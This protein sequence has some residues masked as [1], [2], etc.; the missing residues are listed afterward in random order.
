MSTTPY[1]AEEMEA[2][3]I[4]QRSGL[5]RIVPENEVYKGGEEGTRWWVKL[6]M[7]DPVTLPEDFTQ[8]PK[9]CFLSDRVVGYLWANPGSIGVELRHR[10]WPGDFARAGRLN[11]FKEVRA[12]VGLP[13]VTTEGEIV[14]VRKG[15]SSKYSLLRG[16]MELDELNRPPYNL[17]GPPLHYIPYSYQ[18]LNGAQNRVNHSLVLSIFQDIAAPKTFANGTINLKRKIRCERPTEELASPDASL[19][20]GSRALRSARRLT[21]RL[22]AIQE[23]IESSIGVVETPPVLHGTRIPSIPS[24][25]VA[26]QSPARYESTNKFQSSHSPSN[27]QQG[28][29]RISVGLDSHRPSSARHESAPPD[30]RSEHSD[31]EVGPSF[32]PQRRSMS[33]N[34]RDPPSML[35]YKPL[36]VTQDANSWSTSTLKEFLKTEYGVSQQ[37][38]C[39]FGANKISGRDFIQLQ[40]EAIRNLVFFIPGD[41]EAVLQAHRSLSIGRTQRIVDNL[42]VR[43]SGATSDDTSPKVPLDREQDEERWLKRTERE[44]MQQMQVK[45]QGNEV[46]QTEEDSRSVKD[47]HSPFRA[48]DTPLSVYEQTNGEESD[49][50]GASPIQKHKRAAEIVSNTPPVPSTLGDDD[51]DDNRSSSNAPSSPAPGIEETPSP[52]HDLD[53][54]LTP[55]GSPA[56]PSPALIAR[57][58]F[59]DILVESPFSQNELKRPASPFLIKSQHPRSLSL[60]SQW[61]TQDSNK[62]RR[63]R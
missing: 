31:E 38:G 55:S 26:E 40:E 47:D 28:G 46:L 57:A 7:F 44:F 50:Y 33:H 39:L 10:Y 21:Q 52:R 61:T 45:P 15:T 12:H 8:I 24:P 25:G 14:A 3:R 4:C 30:N 1:S 34:S 58:P 29:T 48:N 59:A 37:G 63:R 41:L 5:S 35:T 51:Y 49:I 13:A 60:E 27:Y 23:Q 2:I 62:K 53:S 16:S 18:E 22:N 54:A 36:Y 32:N 9:R 17:S 19:S 6:Q 42:Q 56:S 20:T 43:S 11:T